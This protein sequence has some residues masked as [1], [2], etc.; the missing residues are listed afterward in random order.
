M[1]KGVKSFLPKRI[2][3]MTPDFNNKKSIYD[4]L[5]FLPQKEEAAPSQAAT[6]GASLT[7][8]EMTQAPVDQNTIN[9]ANTIRQQQSFLT[10]AVMPQI[11]GGQNVLDTG[12][13]QT[14]LNQGSGDNSIQAYLAAGGNPIIGGTGLT[15]QIDLRRLF[16]NQSQQYRSY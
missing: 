11:P 6:M 3:P 5:S 7:P 9:A 4:P 15:P 16:N 1:S 12:S 2:I 13:Q 8:N 14:V 10:P